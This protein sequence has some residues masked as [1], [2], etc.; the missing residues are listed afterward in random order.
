MD[1]G[2][3]SECQKRAQ[4]K[5]DAGHTKQYSLKLNLITDR[6][7]IQ[8]LWGQ[9]SMQGTIKRLIRQEMAREAAEKS[10]KSG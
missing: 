4:A 3:T 8:W 7:I 1:F 2:I 10:K 6:D 9:H 5:Y